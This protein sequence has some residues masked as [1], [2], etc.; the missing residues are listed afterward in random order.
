MLYGTIAWN[1]A[2]GKMPK[3]DSKESIRMCLSIKDPKVKNEWESVNFFLK[4]Y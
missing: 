1:F 4:S 2:A 3:D